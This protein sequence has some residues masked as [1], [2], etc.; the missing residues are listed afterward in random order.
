[1]G[2]TARAAWAVALG[3]AEAAALSG[4]VS[5]LIRVG[6]K[7]ALLGR[8]TAAAG[9]VL[10]VGAVGVSTLALG[11]APQPQ[12]PRKTPVVPDQ[13]PAPKA[14]AKSPPPAPRGAFGAIRGRL[15]WGGDTVPQ[16]AVIV[17]QGLAE[18]DPAFCANKGPILDE[19]L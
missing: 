4:A 6:M 14:Q 8:L 10:I 15:V 11:Q 17:R 2:G 3:H 1:A 9:A 19:R 5:S 16:Q 13:T 18:K 7:S 12:V